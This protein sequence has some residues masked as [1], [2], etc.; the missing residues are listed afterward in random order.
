MRA[1]TAACAAAL[2]ALNVFICRELF[3]AEFIQPMG[4]VEGAYIAI[5]RYTMQNWADRTWWPLWFAGMPWANVYQPGFHVVVAALAG[6]SHVSPVIVYHAV[7][8]VVY[9]LAPVTL[10]VFAYAFSGSRR[11]AFLAGLL[12]SVFSF[13]NILGSV[14]HDLGGWW[15]LRRF[16]CAVHYGEGPH[17]AAIML[18]PLALLFL[19]RAVTRRHWA[20]VLIAPLLVAAIFLTN[21]PGSV[22]FAMMLLAYAVAFG[23]RR[24]PMLLAIVALAY[25][26]CCRWMPPATLWTVVSASQYANGNFP[27]TA[28]HLLVIAAC[29]GLI[30]A[31][32][33]LLRG[34]P[35]YVRLL[36]F[37]VFFTALVPE[38][39]DLT[40]FALLPQPHRWALQMEMMVA[41]AVGYWMTQVKSRAVYGAVVAACLLQAIHVRT[42]AAEALRPV[43]IAARS[44]YKVAMW[45]RGHLPDA[46]VFAPAADSI[47]LNVFGDTPQ[48]GGCCDQGVSNFQSRVALFTIYSGMNAGARDAE[49]SISW[50]KAFGAQAVAIS[51][52]RS[53]EPFHPYAHPF[54]F[55]G[56]LPV[57]WRDGD[58]VIYRVPSATGSLAHVM[59]EQS[60][61]LRPPL[62][63]LDQEAFRPY[64]LALDDPAAPPASFQWTTRHSAHIS[65]NVA[66][67]QIVAVQVSHDP[68]WHAI[69]NGR[70]VSIARNALG[71]MSIHPECSGACSID[72]SYQEPVYPRAITWIS[73]VALAGWVALC[74]L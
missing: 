24:W 15:K 59:P 28:R 1:K 40:G 41:L 66:P 51:G 71:L 20:D 64:L 46:R 22:G 14:R 6:W 37:L 2:F 10:Y 32:W 31:M 25:G 26:L 9:C 68:G 17:T 65:A 35:D 33:W 53:T 52:P 55:D 63:G 72:L 56:V 47:W 43:D 13:S 61:V 60:D 7:V 8:A 12:Y 54:K 36:A 27:F 70:P 3:H 29:A 38:V 50:L 4:S 5:A 73:V 45:F 62:H 34:S 67:G 69:A 18:S 19:H 30:G 57:L 42:F 23:P 39:S 48:V 58:D 74:L 49:Y 21:W 11:Y 44:E 16:Q